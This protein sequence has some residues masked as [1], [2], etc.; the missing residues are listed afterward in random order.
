MKADQLDNADPI[1]RSFMERQLEEGTALAQ[2]SEILRLH[3][4]PLAPPHFIAE[5]NCKGLVS[6]SAGEIREGNHFQ[7][8]I[9]FPPDYLRRVNPLQIVRLF[10]SGIWHPNVSQELPLICLGRLTPGTPLVSILYQVYE[11]LSYQRY[12]PRE[13]DSLNK[14]ACAW[15]RENQHRFPVDRRPLKRRLLNLEVRS[16]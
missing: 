3:V 7:V 6:D 5:F 15:A 8:G 1:Y 11:I 13:N 4:P 9:W 10:T 14:L 2:S 16:A 12:N